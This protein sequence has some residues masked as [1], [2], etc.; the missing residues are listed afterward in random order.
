MSEIF[1]K[2]SL[3]KRAVLLQRHFLKRKKNKEKR[4]VKKTNSNS[5]QRLGKVDDEDLKVFK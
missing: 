2:I 5:N 4:S 3:Q 1:Q